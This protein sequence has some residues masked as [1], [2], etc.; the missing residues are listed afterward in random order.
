MKPFIIYLP[1]IALAALLFTPASFKLYQP[2]ETPFTLTYNKVGFGSNMFAM[3]PVFKISGNSF[4]YTYENAWRWEDRKINRD[5]LLTGYVRQSSVDS[6]SVLISNIKD[7]SVY[8]SDP[9]MSG[10]I[11]YLSIAN[12]IQ[13][14]SFT[15]HNASDST[16]N[17]VVDILNTYIPS[18]LNNLYITNLE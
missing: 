5:T 1:A 13:K 12:N 2:V 14:L 7:T 3:Q 9:F 18:H 16:A 4:T 17:K 6:I 10:S 11:S 15:L 8:K